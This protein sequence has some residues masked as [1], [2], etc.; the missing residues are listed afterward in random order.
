MFELE[1]RLLV[2]VREVFEAR[3]HGFPALP[4]YQPQAA[5]RSFDR[6]LALDSTLAD[7]Y[8]ARGEIRLLELSQPAR[9][10]ADLRHGRLQYQAATRPVPLSYLQAEGAA[11][12]HLHRYPEAQAVYELALGRNPADGRTLFLLGRLAQQTAD[13]ARACDYFRRGAETG[14]PYAVEAAATCDQAA[15]RQKAAARAVWLRRSALPTSLGGLTASKKKENKAKPYLK[16][17]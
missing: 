1:S 12:T 5:E 9:A 3:L 17:L 15:E 4:R 2:F 14:Y 13:S 8:L 16:A 11:L 6:A 7:A 10:L